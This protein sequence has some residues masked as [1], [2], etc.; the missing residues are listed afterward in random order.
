M[1][2]NV[3]FELFDAKRATDDQWHE[4]HAYRVLS[5]E[6]DWPELTPPTLEAMVARFRE[7]QAS[8]GGR[9]TTD[10]PAVLDRVARTSADAVA[11][12]SIAAPQPASST[13]APIRSTTAPPAKAP[14]GAAVS[15]T[16]LRAAR[17]VVRSCGATCSWRWLSDR[18]V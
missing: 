14:S 2:D 18:A 1:G 17:T 4:I 7:C 5:M 12:A 15:R 13:G 16:A 11:I 3:E 10:S 6:H 8:V 9:A